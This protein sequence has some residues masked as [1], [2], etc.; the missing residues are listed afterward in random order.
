MT[1]KGFSVKDMIQEGVT[2]DQMITMLKKQIDDAKDE[3]AAEQERINKAKKAAAAKKKLD[4]DVTRKNAMKACY[5][6]MVALGLVED[7]F[8]DEE[9]DELCDS[10]KE[11]EEHFASYQRILNL[12]KMITE[13]DDD[14]VK[15]PLSAK[16]NSKLADADS[17]IA[18]FL[19]DLE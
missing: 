13:D 14:E 7:N 12:C 15:E 8:T 1:N 2:E 18:R 5:E 4:P 11:A 3:I 16:T 6:H 17:I 19:E 10:L 9:I